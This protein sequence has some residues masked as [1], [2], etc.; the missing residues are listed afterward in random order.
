MPAMYRVV[1][2]LDVHRSSVV[3]TVVAEPPK[4]PSCF[5]HARVRWLRRNGRALREW[6]APRL[7]VGGHGKHR[8]SVEKHLRAI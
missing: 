5:S 6:V 8:C 7:P 1:A 4:G 3:V 2:G